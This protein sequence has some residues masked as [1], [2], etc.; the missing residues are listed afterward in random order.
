MIDL[1]SYATVVI[2]SSLTGLVSW[3]T[4]QRVYRREERARVAA[5]KISAADDLTHRF[6]V[7]MDGYEG[8]ISDLTDEVHRLRLRIDQLS[9]QLKK[10]ATCPYF[11]DHDGTD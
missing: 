8:R 3:I 4:S 11:R 10:C 9:I 6:K 7:L 5:A 1:S 2:G